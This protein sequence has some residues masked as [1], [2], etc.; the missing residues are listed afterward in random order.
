MVVCRMQLKS[1]G[2]LLVFLNK[3]GNILAL[4]TCVKI[5]LYTEEANPYPVFGQPSM[6]QTGQ[7]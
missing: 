5:F 7:S 1:C 4:P 6:N 2:R 3:Q